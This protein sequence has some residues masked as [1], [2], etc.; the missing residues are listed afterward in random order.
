MALSKYTLD[1]TGASKWKIALAVGGTMA[2]GAALYYLL[3]RDDKRKGIQAKTGRKKAADGGE[4]KASSASP[5]IG[6]VA[7]SAAKAEVV[8]TA[9]LVSY[10]T[11]YI[12][13]CFN[14]LLSVK[15]VNLTSYILH[16]RFFYD[17]TRCENI[18]KY[19]CYKRIAVHRVR[20]I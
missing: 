19:I 14:Y 4:N 7:D 8:D 2:A 12:Y 10:L 3:F 15:S 5:N 16:Q 1:D 11:M 18:K 20:I 17:A 9:N 6:T 13:F